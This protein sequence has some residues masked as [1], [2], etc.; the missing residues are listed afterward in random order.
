VTPVRSLTIALVAAFGAVTM[1][2]AG[3][4]ASDHFALGA[5][6][7]GSSRTGP[8]TSEAYPRPAPP[9][10]PK[11]CPPPPV[12]PLPPPPPLGP[13]VVREASIPLVGPPPSRRVALSSISGKGIWLTLWPGARVDATGVVA[14]ARSA[15]LNQLWVRTGSS[16]NGFYGATVLAQ[17]VPAAR[18]AGISV[19]AWD[20]P[21]LSNPAA[22]AAR[23][24]LAFRMG[25]DAFSADIETASEGTYLT[26]RRVRYYLSLV[27]SIAGDRPVIATVP[28]PTSYWLA[29]YPYGAEAPFVDAYAPMVYW[30]CTEPGA[31]VDQA[32]V[33]LSQMRP[34]A[35]IGQDYN[36]GP[37]GGPPG[38][39]SPKEI[40]RFL[41]V[42]HRMGALGASLYDLESG[43]QPQWQALAEYPWAPRVTPGARQ[44]NYRP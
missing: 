16:T 3:V 40:W 9:V 37:E 12:R 23:A 33:A 18:A 27:R 8:A 35:P 36:M 44:E 29:H 19:V 41:D 43:G 34:V 31:A 1:A 6:S 42:A 11:P 25:A 10:Q 22:D 20:F 28:R 15:G 4:A 5:N 7:A 17:L 26:A 14:A 2:P 32:I 39:P 24:G 30:S 13:P 21:N 38:L